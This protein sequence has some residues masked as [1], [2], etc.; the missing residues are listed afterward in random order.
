MGSHGCIPMTIVVLPKGNLPED[1]AVG[2]VSDILTEK[3]VSGIV[4]CKM[5][6][7]NPPPVVRM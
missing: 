2:P 1:K 7:M 3:G 6:K 4:L 5:L